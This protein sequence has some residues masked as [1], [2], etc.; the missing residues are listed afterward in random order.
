MSQEFFKP[1]V[2][3]TRSELSEA[4]YSLTRE[5][6]WSLT[7]KKGRHSILMSKLLHEDFDW[8]CF[9]RTD[10]ESLNDV[11]KRDAALAIYGDIIDQRVPETWRKLSKKLCGPNKK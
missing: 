5:S 9:Q 4:G 6:R 2:K 7:Y 10:P 8:S 1:S 11:E 3:T